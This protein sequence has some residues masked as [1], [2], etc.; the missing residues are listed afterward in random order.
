MELEEKIKIA[1]NIL[2]LTMKA[3]GKMQTRDAMKHACIL[4]E[5]W[6]C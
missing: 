4:K 2:F 6:I 3:G 1:A 5:I